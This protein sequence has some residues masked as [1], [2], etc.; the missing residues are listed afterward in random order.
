[1]MPKARARQR[2]FSVGQVARMCHV[3]R[4]TIRRWIRKHGLPA[5]NTQ[6]GFGIKIPETELRA[7]AERLNVFVDWDALYRDE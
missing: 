4:E 6:R 5:Y 1:M 3:S 2:V 7:F